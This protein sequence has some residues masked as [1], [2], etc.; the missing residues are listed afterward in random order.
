MG[1]PNFTDVV[2]G[3]TQNVRYNVG[4]GHISKNENSGSILN[5]ILGTGE[6]KDAP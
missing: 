4:E 5:V 2:L 1:K 6:R 3:Q